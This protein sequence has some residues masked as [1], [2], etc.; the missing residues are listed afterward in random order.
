MKK[1]FFLIA[2]TFL[3]VQLYAVEQV[4]NQ[5]RI[6]LRHVY[7]FEM[8]K[9]AEL[10]DNIIKKHPADPRGYHYF[11]SIYL[12]KF[13][14]SNDENDYKAFIRYSDFAIS[15]AEKSLE[16]NEN[17]QT[18]LFVLGANNGYRSI[19]FG[20]SEK[21]LEMIWSSKNSNSY[22]NDLIKLN[23][24]FYDA[25][26]GLGLFKFALSQV[27]ST[28]KWALNMIGYSA[29]NKEGIEYLVIAAQKGDLVKVEAEYYLSQIYSEFFS[30]NQKA[31]QLLKNL[32]QKFPA[33]ILFAYSLAVTNMKLRDL[34]SA[35]KKLVKISN[36]KNE[37]FS[38]IISYSN[39]LLGDVNFRRN[40]FL[41]AIEYYKIFLN[42]TKSN[43]Y[44]GIASLRMG[45]CYAML[46]DEN[47]SKI[48]F[49]N[50]GKGNLGLD[51]DI[52][53]A[54]R[55]TEFLT[56]NLSENDK[57]LIRVQNQIENNQSQK[58]YDSLSAFIK[59]DANNKYLNVALLFLA[60]ASFDLNKYDQ[61]FYFAE[62]VTEMKFE[63]EKWVTPL[64]F[65]FLAK[66]S[67]EKKKYSEAIEYL[68]KAE[69]A[70]DFDFA[71]KVSSLVRS[72][73]NKIS[74]N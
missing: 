26:L 54:R 41:E 27:P 11:S 74:F 15:M 61:S 65:Y 62:L 46:G 38:Q 8:D 1:Y 48:Y 7:N 60:D 24:K 23:P 59:N 52:Y 18:A 72:L 51:D 73:R 39:F 37:N 43:D 34:R 2:L 63:N 20:K 47:N 4:Q 68:K 9:A 36:D 28:F 67:I 64:A 53:A 3:S 22:L 17:D 10:F 29:D 35:E 66:N 45:I 49:K 30:E 42:S 12:W 6:G 55:G 13:L 16:K 40:N 25:Y 56:E 32:N 69:K 31:E 71:L 19:A 21:F 33:N 5:I 44:T 57:F 14:G 70:N 58:A 50:S